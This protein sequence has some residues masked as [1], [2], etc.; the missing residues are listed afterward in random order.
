[1]IK[2][3]ATALAL[4][5]FSCCEP[6]R[7]IYRQ[8]G[9]RLGGKRRTLGKMPPYYFERAER[10]VRYCR[11]YLPLRKDDLILE[12]GTGW[13]HWE[14]LTLRL[15]FDFRAVLY[16][17]WDNRQ[18]SALKSYAS[19]LQ[20]RFGQK[21]FLEGCNF[22]RARSLIREIQAASTFQDLYDLLG[23]EYVLDSS[24]LMANLPKSAFRLAISAGVM[25]HIPAATAPA[26]VTKM[27]AL[28]A[29]GGVGIHGINVSDHLALYD[30]SANLKQYLVYPEWL[31]KFCYQNKVQYIN[32]IQ[33]S[34]W[35]RMFE[36]AGFSL[37]EE[38]GSY[39]DTSSIRIHQR[40]RGLSQQ[41]IDCTTLVLVVQKN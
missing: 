11:K 17:V 18:L 19:Q 37:L 23:F 1:M 28:L 41:D 14:A 9:N 8:L 24:G 31:W 20:E 32:R 10:N 34:E 36:S 6:A 2:Y 7:A 13:M 39:T 4:K 29:R 16:D 15:F 3:H 30:A 35:L 12:L 5:G 21:G 22:D 38:G 27:A 25:E 40:F 33:R 26:F